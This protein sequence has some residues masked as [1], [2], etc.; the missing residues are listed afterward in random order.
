MKTLTYL[1]VGVPCMK[2]LT[3]LLVGVSCMK[4]LTCLLVG[5]PCM[6]TLTCL[7]VGVSSGPRGQ[8]S[9]AESRTVRPAVAG[10][11]VDVLGRYEGHQSN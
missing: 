4:T 5:V 1:R 3:C 6:K 9:R 7:L 10:A 8:H 11:A 2:T